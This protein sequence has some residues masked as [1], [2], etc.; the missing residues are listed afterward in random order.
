[1]R[2]QEYEN[3]W[4]RGC[5]DKMVKQM[6]I[7]MLWPAS[8]SDVTKAVNAWTSRNIWPDVKYTQSIP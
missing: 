2:R 5:R 7:D 3:R 1:M 8:M 6:T 4:A